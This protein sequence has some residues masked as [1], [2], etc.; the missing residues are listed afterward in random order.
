MVA[1]VIFDKVD[2]G[3]CRHA[4]ALATAKRAVDLAHRLEQQ[5]ERPA[6]DDQVMGLGC[7]PVT[8]AIEANQTEA[9]Q[10]V[11]AQ[12]K[13]LRHLCFNQRPGRRLWIGLP[14]EIKQ[15]HGHRQRLR[16]PLQ[17][18]PVVTHVRSQNN[19]QGIIRF[20]QTLKRRLQQCRIQWPGQLHVT[21]NVV[22]RRISAAQLVQPDIPLG[23]S[24]RECLD[25]H[26]Q[27]VRHVGR[28]RLHKILLMKFC[29]Y[30]SIGPG[31]DMTPETRTTTRL[32]RACLT[33]RACLP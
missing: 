12:H 5:R 7:Q 4:R 19:A 17:R 2:I 20:H 33:L 16:K 21:A 25:R 14:A 8:M 29:R 32:V 18:Q 3:R 9:E 22:Q 11:P 31:A 28:S 24:Q 15:R 26:G 6:I 27:I 30:S 1:R 13:G 23:G 10:R